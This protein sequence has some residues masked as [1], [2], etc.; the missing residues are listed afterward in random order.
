M[1]EGLII[2]GRRVPV[3]G[4]RVVTWEDDPRVPKAVHGAPRDPSSVT[5]SVAHTSRGKRA[6]VTRETGSPAKG[7]RVARYL[8]RENRRQ[9]SAHVVIA[10][11]GTVYQLADLATWRANHAGT[12]N[13]HTFGVEVAQD[14]DDPSLT[15]AQVRAFVAVMV[16]A[17]GAMGLAKVVPME[18][19][20][21]VV[22]DVG[23][24]LSRKS[25]GR[26]LGFAGCAG[27][28]NT[29]ASRGEGDPGTPLMEAL[30]AAGFA[31]A[32]PAE[33]TRDGGARCDDDDRPAAEDGDVDGEAAWPP[34]PAWLDPAREV[35][36]RDDLPD[37][38]AAM[39]RAQARELEAIGVTGD[40][41]AE[42]LA[43]AATECARGARAIGHNYGGI[44]A[45]ERD[46]AAAVAKTG[47]GL[48]W[49]RDHGHAGSGDGAVVYYRAFED[50]GE[51]WRFFVKRFVG[52]PSQPPES[53]R[54]AAA[55]RAFWGPTPAGWFVELVRAGYRGEVRERELEELDARGAAEE[56]PSVKGHRDVARRVRMLLRDT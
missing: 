6:G 31:G 24:W 41:A 16:A 49:W 22:G 54:Y 51:F 7:L 34:P 2:D 56:H 29:S 26:Q 1:S 8:G 39:V 36:A 25:G 3:P 27:H 9:V 46:N 13:G 40:R 53:A 20:E 11:D 33:M 14:D 12:A 32:T 5:G 45:K 19:G 38:L 30:R 23:A 43:H 15:R 55:G 50:D 10:G 17:H 37:D 47:V 18:R 44:K 52:G 35:D 28:R 21:H 48:R 4:V 42:L